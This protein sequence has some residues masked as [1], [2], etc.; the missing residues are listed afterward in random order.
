M[1]VVASR[2]VG[3]WTFSRLEGGG[4]WRCEA[5]RRYPDGTTLAFL[6]VKPGPG[7]QSAADTGL[8]FSA[9]A[10]RGMRGPIRVVPWGYGPEYP[11]TAV[12]DG[13]G[14]ATLMD[15]PNEPGSADGFANGREFEVVLPGGVRLRYALTG[16]NAAF[17]A[18]AQCGGF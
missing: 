3:E 15:P 4:T 10:L 16:S 14:S 8:R 12:A 17:R 2:A 5:E 18:V 9:P 11:H 1:R 7:S 13:N 6:A